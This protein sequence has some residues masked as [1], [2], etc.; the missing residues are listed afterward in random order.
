MFHCKKKEWT[1]AKWWVKT[2]NDTQRLEYH[3]YDIPSI[4]APMKDRW[5]ALTYAKCSDRVKPVTTIKVNGDLHDGIKHYHDE[6]IKDGYEGIIIRDYMAKYL[7][8]HRGAELL[9]YKEFIDAEFRIVGYKEGSDGGVTFKLRTGG[10][11]SN[12]GILRYK[13]FDCRPIGTMEHRRDLYQNGWRYAGKMLTVRFQ[14][15]SDDNVPIF[16]VGIAF[17][18]YE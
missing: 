10:S 9:K 4:N 3:R 1:E 13:Y 11:R 12:G 17:R 14:E 7:W 18:D 2:R 6:F 5:I 16:P 15:Y 8:K